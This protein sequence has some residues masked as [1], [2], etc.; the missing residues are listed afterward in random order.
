MLRLLIPLMLVAAPAEAET[1]IAARNIRAQQIIGPGDLTVIEGDVIGTYAALDEAMGLEARNVLYAG[2]PVRIE[3]LGPPAIVDRNQIVTIVYEVG[4]M[5]IAAEGRALARGGI[6]DV[7]RV[8][9][10]SSHAVISGR[11]LPNGAVTVSP[12]TLPMN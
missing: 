8:M 9:N 11:V 1:L 4:A 3:D 10:L 6:G 7:L 5:Q 12:T 2:R